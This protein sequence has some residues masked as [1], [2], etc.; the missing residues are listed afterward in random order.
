MPV[1]AEQQVDR[2]L[3]NERLVATQLL[4]PLARGGLLDLDDRNVLIVFRIDVL[5]SPVGPD[6][7]LD[8]TDL[9][10]GIVGWNRSRQLVFDG[11]A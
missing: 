6:H 1:D 11:I 2:G 7:V 4:K 3:G 10:V 9:A 5:H 8:V